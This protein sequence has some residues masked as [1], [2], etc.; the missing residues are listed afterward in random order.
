MNRAELALWNRRPV[1][2]KGLILYSIWQQ[3]SLGIKSPWDKPS[4]SESNELTPTL[5]VEPWRTK[6]TDS[7]EN[8]VTIIWRLCC[9]LSGD[10]EPQTSILLLQWIQWISTP[11]PTSYKICISSHIISNLCFTLKT[12]SFK[13]LEW[14]FCLYGEEICHP[15]TWAT[16]PAVQVFWSAASRGDNQHSI[17]SR[18]PAH[19]SS[20]NTVVL[21]HREKQKLQAN[22]LSLWLA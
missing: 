8:V 2:K 18:V 3:N 1:I 9:N 17:H 6:Q 21:A 15:E 19:Q 11:I 20:P 10:D 4:L 14:K 13:R 16:K 22:N 7:Q 5:T 12:R